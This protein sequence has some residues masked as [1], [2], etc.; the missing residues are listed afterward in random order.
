VRLAAVV[1]VAATAVL[2]FPAPEAGAELRFKRC[3][4][5]PFPCARLSVPLDRSG[6]TPGR[7]SL[8][9]GRVRA[10]EQPRR[11]AVFALAGGPGQSASLGFGIDGLGPLEHAL[12]RRDLIV[13][14][15]RGTGRSGLLRCRALERADLLDAGTAAGVC[16]RRL[17]A[18]RHHYTSRA[19]VD[20]IEAI[21][22]ELGIPRITLYGT[23]YGA[24]VAL[25]YALTYP[26]NVERL[27]LDS[28]VAPDGLDPFY[29]PS[30]AA[31]PR[32]MRALCRSRCRSF[33]RDPVADLGGLV[34]RMAA[35]P[36]RGYVVD[37]HGRRRRTR[38]TRGELFLLLVAGD[39]GP[40]LRA[41]FPGAVRAA[42]DGDAEPALRL[43]HR[44]LSDP[45]GPLPPR[46]ISPALFA[47]TICEETPFP[48]PRMTPPDPAERRRLAESA[49]TSI[50]ADAF[51]PF[52][53]GATLGNNLLQ[54][55]D[56]WAAAPTA[57]SFGPGPLPDVPVLLLGGEDDLRTPVESA[58]RVAAGFPRA[59]V[60]VASATGHSALAREPTG[61]MERAVARFFRNQPVLRCGR[62]RRPTPAIPPPPRRLRDVQR[63]A[64]VPGVRG[65]ALS[66]LALTLRDVAD[67]FQYTHSAGGGLRGGRYRFDDDGTLH[68]RRVAF[69][70]GVR[71]SGRLRHFAARRQRGGVLLSGP[72]TPDGSLLVR[73]RRLS[74]RL[75]GRPVSA[76]LAVPT[77]VAAAARRRA[78]S[79]PLV[80]AVP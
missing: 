45:A 13:F 33:T 11:G 74:G 78:A 62:A 80:A 46:A 37:P 24:K 50:P 17:G 60:L 38:L 65:R 79:R 63:A 58:E 15:Q 43:K 67:D 42:L 55:C 75:G 12:R 68:L 48:W 39:F 25:G 31:V 44:A 40:E 6:A 47:A 71:V 61:C 35:R 27:L 32:V 2:L 56:H 30:L 57:P 76:R 36:L 7:V 16:A 51:G 20:D 49:L 29:L 22:R 73:G 8:F 53:R 64:G 5:F 70:P 54:L 21:R 19:S 72:A 52:D 18:R 1:L 4:P 14:D 59:R 28:V 69:V 10:R 34:R 3:E 66:A 9:V 26:G 77:G 23:S 41:A